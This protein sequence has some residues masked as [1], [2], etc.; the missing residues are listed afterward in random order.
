MNLKSIRCL[1]LLLL[2]P[3]TARP[4]T[5]PRIVCVAN[6]KQVDMAVYLW[7]QDNHLSDTNS[8]SLSDDAVR[9][10]LS[11]SN[12]V[13]CPAGGTYVAGKT[14]A[15]AV[16]CTFHG[17][18][19]EMRREYEV[20][21]RRHNGIQVAMGIAAVL[22]AWSMLRGF[23]HAQSSGQI[24]EPVRQILGPS[25]LFLLGLL[26]LVMPQ[27]SLRPTF[28]ITRPVLNVPTAVLLFY[29]LVVTIWSMLKAR[30]MRLIV[31][32]SLGMVFIALLCLIV[33]SWRR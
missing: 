20:A 4:D 22:L 10:Y 25:L 26:V 23:K 12:M 17:S 30:K 24:S 6:L 31:L 3:Q 21:R 33:N 8:Y 27:D 14:V 9:R 32:C 28:G 1:F 11:K 19:E 29:G 18:F 5:N 2:V 7:A 15:N 13:V 16:R